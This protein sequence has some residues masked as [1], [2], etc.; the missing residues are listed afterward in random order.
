MARK[1]KV[2]LAAVLPWCGF[3]GLGGYEL[4]RARLARHQTDLIRSQLDQL[5]TKTM[6][7]PNFVGQS[8]SGVFTV[9]ASTDFEGL[10][11]MVYVL[12]H[13]KPVFQFAYIRPPRS[14]PESLFVSIYG[15]E[16]DR[17]LDV[18]AQVGR[19]F[20]SYVVYYPPGGPDGGEFFYGD[21]DL[22]GKFEKKAKRWF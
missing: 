4:Y 19:D 17:F 16:G 21:Y 12:A 9:A 15:R 22:D 10:D 20:P 3:V 18:G 7:G 13:G 11:E 8:R 2:L 6:K 5:R 14:R 1:L